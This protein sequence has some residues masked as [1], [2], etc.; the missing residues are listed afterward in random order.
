MYSP[1]KTTSATAATGIPIANN[2]ISQMFAAI[3]PMRRPPMTA[4]MMTGKWPH[5]V[6][7]F[8]PVICTPELPVGRY[9]L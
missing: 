6:L 8:S 1:R 5:K 9:A 4:R 3:M 7:L 2:K